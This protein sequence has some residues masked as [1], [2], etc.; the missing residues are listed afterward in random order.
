ME[1]A[2]ARPNGGPRCAVLVIAAF[3][4]TWGA[5]PAVAGTLA[6]V[7]GHLAP[8]REAAVLHALEELGLDAPR[9]VSAD[10]VV[11]SVD[12]IRVEGLPGEADC[13]RRVKVDEWRGRF[14]RA[15]GQLQLLAFAEALSALVALDLELVCLA[16]PPASSDLFRLELALAEA[17]TFL[18]QSAAGDLDK[19]GFHTSE[20]DAALRRAAEFGATL[21]VPPDLAP[22]V[23]GAYERVRARR[24]PDAPR[25]VVVGPDARV[26]ARFNGRP[27]PETAFDAVRGTNLVQAASGSV[28]TAAAR[29]RLTTGRSLL[30]LAAE[31]V[32]PVEL[33]AAVSSLETPEGPDDAAAQLLVG[34][35]R[36][37]GDGGQAVFVVDTA[38]AVVVWRVDGSQLVA[39]RVGVEE[40]PLD[41]WRFALGAGPAIGWSTLQEGPLDGLGGLNAGA[42]LSARI[43]ATRW[44]SVALTV[45]PWVVASPIAESQGGGTLFRATIPA[46]AGVRF[47]PHARRVAFEGGVDVGLHAFGRFGEGDAARDRYSFLAS[48][49]LGLA[50]GVGPHAGVRVQAW[51][52]AGLGY[53]AGG[54]SVGVEGR[55]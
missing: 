17:H 23:F 37:T 20:A 48:G 2:V 44:L 26:G 30:W 31:P 19:R 11:S 36:L 8:G 13:E 38:R 5:T 28:V 15:R 14:E 32:L 49:A 34:L 1:R 4:S 33:G 39:T 12:V 51:F 9:L 3:L 50:V 55:L 35:A 22:E 18:A 47:G 25:V 42:A 16:S 29:V 52:G 54:A 46:R 45:D 10:S 40:P 24:D 43:A 6:I 53:V 21:S 41:E 7:P 27:L